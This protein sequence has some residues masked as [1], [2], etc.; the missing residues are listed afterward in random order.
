MSE[1]T[2]DINFGDIRAIS[3]AWKLFCGG[4]D[5]NRRTAVVSRDRYAPLCIRAIALC[6]VG[7]GLAVFRSLEEARRWLDEPA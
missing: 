3:E 2:G 6:F 1:F 5:R 7:R 4:R